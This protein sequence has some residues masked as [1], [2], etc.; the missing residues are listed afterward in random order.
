ARLADVDVVLGHRLTSRD[1]QV[2]DALAGLY[3]VAAPAPG[4]WA[5]TTLPEDRPG[6][7]G[8]AALLAEHSTSTSSAPIFRG[9]LV[10]TQLLCEQIPPAPA[11]AMANTP[12]YPPGSTERERTKI[13]MTHMNCGACHVLMNPIGLGFEHFD[14]TGAWRELDVDGSLV[15]DSGEILPDTGGVAGEF[16][17]LPALASK[18]ADD[19]DVAACFATQFYRHALGLEAS[20]VMQCAIEPVQQTFANSGGDIPTLLTALVRSDAFR[21]RV[22]EEQ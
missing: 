5:A 21:M 4:E 6:L 8:R 19:D 20:E 2:N 14:A 12:E 17:G 11:D 9:R 1:T 16:D 3:G 10:R 7:L 18:L 22:L 13:L 15:D